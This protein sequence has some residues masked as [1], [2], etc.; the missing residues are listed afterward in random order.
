MEY[1][2]LLTKIFSSLTSLDLDYYKFIDADACFISHPMT[3]HVRRS[4]IKQAFSLFFD[5][6][7]EYDL[8]WL[9]DSENIGFSF[10]Y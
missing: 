9:L 8:S 4:V 5:G 6:T 3:Q 1:P 7:N 10:D 2:D